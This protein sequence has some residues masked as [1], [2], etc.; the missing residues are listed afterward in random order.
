M[1]GSSPNKIAQTV[2]FFGP[3]PADRAFNDCVV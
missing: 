3:D 2:M 1:I